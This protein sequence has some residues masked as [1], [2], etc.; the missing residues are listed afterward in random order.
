MDY[1]FNNN[2]YYTDGQALSTDGS[3]AYANL[4]L[5]FVSFYHL[6]SGQ[7]LYFKAIMQSLDDNYQSQWKGEDV[8][9]RSDPIYTYQSTKRNINFYLILPSSTIGEA[10]ENLA[11]VQKMIQFSYPYYEKSGFAQTITQSPLVRLKAFNLIS[12]N[13]HAPVSLSNEGLSISKE[14]KYGLLGFLSNINMDPQVAESEIGAITGENV[15]IPKTIKFNLSFTPIHENPLGW[16]SDGFSTPSNRNFPYNIDQSLD[17]AVQYDVEAVEASYDSFDPDVED[18][19]DDD[20]GTPD[21]ASA[22][23]ENAKAAASGD[24]GGDDAPVEFE[25][26]F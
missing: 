21:W 5:M 25:D 12:S 13:N 3:D 20:A 16:S 11:K 2:K 18:A 8:Y 24:G 26:F 14:P 17:G 4:D 19:E 9:G 15:V 6:P 22:L 1:I 23:E 10:M 7:A